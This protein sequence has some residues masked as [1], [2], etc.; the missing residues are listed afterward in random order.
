MVKLIAL[1]SMLTGIGAT[2]LA[3]AIQLDPGTLTVPVTRLEESVPV[4]VPKVVQTLVPEVVITGHVFKTTTV[5]K[6]RVKPATCKDGEWRVIGFEGPTDAR[7]NFLGV[8]LRCP[9]GK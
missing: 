7:T 3:I 4:V 1:S 5:P 8:T 6:N 9:R 2:G